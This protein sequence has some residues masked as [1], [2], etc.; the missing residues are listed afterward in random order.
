MAS[1]IISTTPVSASI[2]PQFFLVPA[3]I[4]E[5]P[6]QL[7][8]NPLHRNHADRHDRALHLGHQPVNLVGD[9]LLDLQ[10]SPLIQRLIQQKH[11]NHHLSGQALQL[12]QPLRAHAEKLR[13]LTAFRS[14][15]LRPF[16]RLRQRRFPLQLAA[17][18]KQ[19][20]L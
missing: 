5:N 19:A 15:K 7:W 8:H 18:H 16:L 11:L 10:Q 13:L 14:R 12:V 3:N 6:P 1:E 2:S 20:V 4:S 9:A 17:L